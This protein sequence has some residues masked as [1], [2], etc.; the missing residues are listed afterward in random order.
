MLLKSFLKR[1]SHLFGVA[2][3]YGDITGI[4]TLEDVIES[5]LGEE[6]VD[7]VDSA[8]DMQ[9]VAQ[10]RKRERN[11]DESASDDDDKK[12]SADA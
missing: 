8:V 2:D 10:R 9:D 11:Q 7:E 1:R 5:M 3:E 6:I 12:K 4:V